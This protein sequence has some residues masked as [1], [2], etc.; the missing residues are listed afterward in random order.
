MLTATNPTM[1]LWKK[2]GSYVH[3]FS[4]WPLAVWVSFGVMLFSRAVTGHFRGAHPSNK[5]LLTLAVLLPVLSCT[6]RSIRLFGHRNFNSIELDRLN[7]LIALFLPSLS[8]VF[9]GV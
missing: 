3:R 8:L 5:L 7:S 6:V 4:V 1:S 9:C 2:L